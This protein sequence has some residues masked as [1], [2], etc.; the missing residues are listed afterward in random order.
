MRSRASASL[1]LAIGVSACTCAPAPHDEMPPAP[2]APVAQA[3]APRP[4]A[5][6]GQVLASPRSE[7]GASPSAEVAVVPERE[8]V[9]F[10]SARLQEA[11]AALRRLADARD[12]AARDAAAALAENDRRDQE[13]K[14]AM[15]TDLRRRVEVVMRRP[16]GPAEVQAEHADLLARRKASY[17]RAV[18]AGKRSLESERT[19]A[20]LEAAA[21]RYRDARF[22][23]QGMPS[24]VQATR[25]DASGAFALAVPPGRYALVALT[26][27]APADRTDGPAWLLWMEVRDGASEPVVLD[28]T[29]QH[30]SD[31]ETCI[32]LVKELP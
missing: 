2:V 19:L 3:A 24:A 9:E 26:A 20:G 28:A 1:L 18:A 10:V 21:R 12:R 13:W 32:V 14:V 4:P 7:G 11:H 6:R 23:T 25:T 31:C 8:M 29:N 30:G 22:F 17:G 27:A 16:S 15:A 5:I